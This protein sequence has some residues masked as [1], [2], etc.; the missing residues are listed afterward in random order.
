LLVI[1]GLLFI[2]TNLV[3]DIMALLLFGTIIVIQYI[4]KKPIGKEKQYEKM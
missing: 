3:T 1:A 4:Q 2:A